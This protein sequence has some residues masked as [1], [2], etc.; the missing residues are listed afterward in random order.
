[1]RTEFD[2]YYGVECEQFSFLRVPKLL[3]KDE[4]FK[5]LSSDAKLLYGL[6]LDRMSL[7]MKNGWFDK[8]NRVYIIYTI[9]TI[10]EDLGCGKDK[11]IKVLAELDI[12]KGVG[13]IEKFR[14]GFGKPDII[15]IKNFISL[16]D[17]AKELPEEDNDTE[18]KKADFKKS[19]KST[20]QG[21]E[22]RLQEVEKTDTNNTNNINNN[23]ISDNNLINH[24]DEQ[25]D[26]I[27]NT[28]INTYTQ[29]IKSNIEYEHYML[30]ADIDEREQYE[31]LF[32]TIVDVVCVNRKMIKIG[33]EEYPYALVKARFLKLNTN[34]LQYVM[35]CMKKTNTKIGNIKAYMLTA[36]YNAVGTINHYY[37]QAVQYD[38]YGN[39][40]NKLP[41]N[42]QKE[43]SNFKQ[44]DI[45]ELEHE[46]LGFC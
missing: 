32:Q 15:Y 33:G 7:S 10:M 41:N 30:Y 14:R 8:E 3:F 45:D 27:D 5:K 42:H 29:I 17:N 16:K 34:H 2:Y 11:A 12:A 21:R 28:D 39:E 4:R 36:L 9:S 25:I 18:V 40:D 43:F 1:M 44:R 13:L 23:D 35:E 22:N 31:E 46:L 37:Q 20:S 19:E 24:I 38:M 6:M 26:K